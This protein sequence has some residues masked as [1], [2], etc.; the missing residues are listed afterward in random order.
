M[1]VDNVGP[2]EEFPDFQEDPHAFR[3]QKNVFF[4]YVTIFIDIFNLSGKV[5]FFE[6]FNDLLIHL[7]WM[8]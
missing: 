1:E 8:R 3:K 6:K 4:M 5:F 7:K 2:S